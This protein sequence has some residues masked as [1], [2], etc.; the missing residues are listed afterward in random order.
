MADVSPSATA[1]HERDTHRQ[2]AVVIS[3]GASTYRATV[4]DL[5]GCAA[6]CRTPGEVEYVIARAIAGHIR[7]L[8]SQGRPVP[9]PQTYVVLVDGE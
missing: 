6:V 5:P 2:Y 3:K 8:R 9:E 7:G 4:P 1:N